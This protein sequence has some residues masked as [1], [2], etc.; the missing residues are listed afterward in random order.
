MKPYDVICELVKDNFLYTSQPKIENL[1]PID[2][3]FHGYG[4]GGGVMPI[5]FEPHEDYTEEYKTGVLY[6]TSPS[7]HEDFSEG[8]SK[9]CDTDNEGERMGELIQANSDI[10][11]YNIWAR[12]K[13]KR[14]IEEVMVTLPHDGKV[15][16]AAELKLE[17][18]Y[19]PTIREH[20]L[21]ANS[22]RIASPHL[23]NPATEL[24]IVTIDDEALYHLKESLDANE[25]VQRFN[26]GVFAY[27]QDRITQEKDLEA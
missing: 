4:A 6:T 20:D 27:I 9:R 3:V 25:F 14:H 16:E 5:V 22:F 21:W 8:Y 17:N 26:A 23:S 7:P 12:E 15:Y 2:M 18:K 19:Y 13:N 10:A 11:N 24:K 1:L